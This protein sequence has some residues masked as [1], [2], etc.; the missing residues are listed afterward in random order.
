M[1][2]RRTIDG[3]SAQ[4]LMIIQSQPRRHISRLYDSGPRSI[5]NSY[6]RSYTSCSNIGFPNCGLRHCRDGARHE[7]FRSKRKEA[8]RASRRVAGRGR[9]NGRDACQARH[10]R[11]VPQSRA[12]A[13]GVHI[14]IRSAAERPDLGAG[15]GTSPQR[16]WA[17]AGARRMLEITAS[18]SNLLRHLRVLCHRAIARHLYRN[19]ITSPALLSRIPMQRVTRNRP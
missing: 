7:D 15:F 6:A 9:P 8:L 18:I 17:G 16:L 13:G 12:L 2:S 5:W 11:P 10:G 19:P 3:R 1:P 4:T 14:F